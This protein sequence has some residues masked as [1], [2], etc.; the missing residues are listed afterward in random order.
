MIGFA[1]V[2]SLLAMCWVPREPNKTFFIGALIGGV[3]GMIGKNKQAKEQRQQDA[4]DYER[5]RPITQVKEWET[6]GINP[7]MGLTSGAFVPSRQTA[8]G[9]RFSEAGAFFAEAADQFGERHLKETAIKQENS[10]LKKELDRTQKASE[11]SEFRRNIDRLPGVA[12][13]R[14]APESSVRPIT[15]K[16]GEF[17]IEGEANRLEIEKGGSPKDES[18]Y[19]MDLPFVGKYHSS[20]PMFSDRIEGYA[21]DLWSLPYIAAQQVEDLWHNAK[22]D[23]FDVNRQEWTPLIRGARP[24]PKG[25]NK[26]RIRGPKAERMSEQ[27]LDFM[28]SNYPTAFD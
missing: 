1:I 20:R 17:K 21:G 26:A 27:T 11:P 10:A 7:I 22:G 19:E 8:V 12:S 6:A 24:E 18:I 5:N 2:L 28:K 9:D 3:L 13:T 23:Y 25:T 14:S 4:V 15:V 16:K